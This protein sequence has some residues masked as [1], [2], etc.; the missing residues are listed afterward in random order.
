M[1][2]CTT[3]LFLFLVTSQCFALNYDLQQA[4]NSAVIKHKTQLLFVTNK[5]QY[6]LVMY[7]K[8]VKISCINF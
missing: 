8:E 6:H 3:T 1:Q 4:I 2:L 7:C 5:T